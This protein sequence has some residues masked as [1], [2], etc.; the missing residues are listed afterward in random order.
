MSKAADRLDLA[1]T[2]L[3]VVDAGSLSAAARSLGLTQPTV[4]RQ[5]AQLEKMLGIQLL[6]RT[7]HD[8]SL[9]EAGAEFLNE[10]RTLVAHWDGIFEKLKMD[11]EAP[12]GLLRL[13]APTGLGQ[14]ELVDVIAEL[15][16]RHEGLSV[17][18]RL[19][20][21]PPDLTA[22]G[23][24]MQITVG[25]PRNELL[26]A[27]KIGD[28]KRSLVASKE[29]AA[30]YGPIVHPRDLARYDACILSG[31]FDGRMPLVGAKGQEFEID[32]RPRFA[33]DSFHAVKR[34]ILLSV[35]YGFL[36]DWLIGPELATRELIRLLPSWRLPNAP[37][38][39]AWPK[40]RYLPQRVRSAADL[41]SARLKALLG[42]SD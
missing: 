39:M 31:Y 25:P 27:R 13:Y 9:T 26:V 11:R 6:R 37:L 33:S 1:Q 24:D 8:T 42:N 40:D 12:R 19:I 4:S 20:D 18:L 2:F 29:W 10:A 16:R 35:G 34:G 23:F 17:E 5:I 38:F 22:T 30:T 3:R 41:I 15:H 32:L 21:K 36:P 28:I 7:T 14:Q